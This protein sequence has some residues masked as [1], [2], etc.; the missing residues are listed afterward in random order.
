MR[1]APKPTQLYSPLSYP[2]GMGRK[3]RVLADWEALENVAIA[4]ASPV[5]TSNRTII[6]SMGFTT[7]GP[8]K[9]RI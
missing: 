4:C 6:S 2:S 9:P 7:N 8:L 5:G 3:L 1:F